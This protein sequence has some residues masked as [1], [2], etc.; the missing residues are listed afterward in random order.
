M[1]T[2]PDPAE[3]PADDDATAALLRGVLH[4][5]ADAVHPSPDGLAR[6][7][8]AAHARDDQDA[9]HDTHYDTHHDTD[10]DT[11]HDAGQDARRPA[12]PNPTGRT[13]EIETTPRPGTARPLVPS[14]RG[15]ASRRHTRWLPLAAAA[16]VVAVLFGGLGAVRF[17]VID[18]PGLASVVG[19]PHSDEGR[20]APLAP[21]PLPVYLVSR[22]EGRWA[23]VR[24]FAATSLTDPQER[25]EAAL[26]LA[27]EG[28]ASDPD[29]T[30]VWAAE[31]LTGDVR[32]EVQGDT[33]EVRLAPSLLGSATG[34]VTDAPRLTL[35]RL[36]AQQ[37]VW[38]ATAVAAR[39]VPV[40]VTTLDGTGRPAA[41][42]GS[43]P[44]AD[45]FRRATGDGD[46]RAPVW[47]SSVEDGQQLRRGTA[48]ISGDAATTAARSVRWSLIRAADEAVVTRGTADLTRVD[49]RSPEV[50]ERGV[51]SIRLSVPAAGRYRLAVEQDWAGDASRAPWTDTKTLVVG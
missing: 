32:A 3:G 11:D 38:T 22:Q 50:G 7:L 43:L 34:P 23:L 17:G 51:F 46:L 9:D 29:L 21:Q 40:R 42:L 1:S 28:T 48:V 18:S 35:A 49:G 16:A 31:R 4:R 6:I 33:I 20:R 14:P 30:S 27:V 19:A 12:V 44:L 8:A 39:D 26:R 36:A 25:L 10:H 15:G 37:L 45:P 13:V 41:L 47:V 5:Q 2:R 24:E